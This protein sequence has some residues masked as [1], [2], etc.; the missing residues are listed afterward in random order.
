M[1]ISYFLF[2]FGCILRCVAHLLAPQVRILTVNSG[3]GS[4]MWMVVLGRAISGSGGAGIMTI[5]SV[6]I[7]DVVPKREIVGDS[8]RQIAP[9][10]L[11]SENPLLRANTASRLVIAPTSMS[12]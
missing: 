9:E 11:N 8:M 3:I 2:A 6:I 5:S 10:R 7:T 1:L 12:P 4:Q